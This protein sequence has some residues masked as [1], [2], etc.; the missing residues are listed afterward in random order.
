MLVGLRKAWS[1]DEFHEESAT[2]AGQ[3]TWL[4]AHES[5]A[6]YQVSLEFV[7]WFHALP[8]ARELSSRLFRQIDKAATSVV[9]NIAEGNGRCLKGDRRS[10]LEIAESSAVKS[11]TYL[12]LCE[13][14]AEVD[15][16][17]KRSR[18]S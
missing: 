9:L 10:F 18:L 13:R 6:A 15:L 14:T 16:R 7:G 3:E 4:F 12:D 5:L 17:Q 1:D 2:Y 11:A 8:K